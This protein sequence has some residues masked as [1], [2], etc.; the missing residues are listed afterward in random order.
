MVK[1]TNKHKHLIKKDDGEESKNDDNNSDEE[2]EV[3]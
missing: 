3:A 1:K 2:I